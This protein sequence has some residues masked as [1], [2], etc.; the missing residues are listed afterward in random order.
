MNQPQKTKTFGE[1]TSHFIIIYVLP[2]F[3]VGYIN[4]TKCWPYE[5]IQ[6]FY[7]NTAGERNQ[8][9]ND[10]IIYTF[11]FVVIV[12]FFYGIRYVIKKNIL[13]IRRMR[14]KFLIL[15][16]LFITAFVYFFHFIKKIASTL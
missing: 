15:I 4:Y 9:V 3:C 11:S 16:R 14:S 13:I 8:W 12:A 1:K 2:T 10:D 5:T 7:K 6:A